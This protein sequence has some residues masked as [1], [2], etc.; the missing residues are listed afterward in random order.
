[1]IASGVTPSGAP[2]TRPLCPHPQVA[3]YNGTGN[4][5]EEASF[6]CEAPAGASAGGT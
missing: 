6:T 5:D 1:V 2:R 3:H 4:S